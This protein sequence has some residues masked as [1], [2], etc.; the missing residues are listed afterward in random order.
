MYRLLTIA[1]ALAA[2]ASPALAQPAPAPG[3]FLFISPSGEPFRSE[4]GLADWFAGA[5]A[6]H[7][8]ALTL[9]ELRDD[10]MRFFK[11]LDADASGWIESPENTAY[12]TRIAPE[13]TRP[14]VAGR[15]PAKRPLIHKS[16]RNVQPKIG[17]ARFSLL[18][19]PQPVRGADADLNQRVSS[20]EWAKA[21]RRRF[22]ILDTDKDGKLT[23]ETF[24]ARLDR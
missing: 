17:A 1:A 6:S 19:E 11:V 7:D 23:L 18:N 5:D 12:E 21:A 3:V 24:R 8:G 9:V 14:D 13:I 16:T 20:E 22:E 15:P 2:V 10:A 4:D